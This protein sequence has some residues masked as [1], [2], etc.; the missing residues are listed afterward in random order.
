MRYPT[1][2]KTLIDKLKDGDSVSWDE[3]YEKY[4]KIIIDVGHAKGLTDDECNDLVQEVMLRFFQ[5]S[6]TFKFDPNI[7]KFRTYFSRIVAGKIIDI[8]RR[9]LHTFPEISKF[10]EFEFGTD[11]PPDVIFDDIIL[12]KWRK[13]LL[14]Q[15]KEILR[16][17][18]NAKT[19]SAFE[20]YAEQQRDV[21]RVSEALEM[22]E[23]QIYV[24]KNRCL[25]LLNTILRELHDADPEVE[26][27]THGV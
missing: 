16:S 5:K 19:Y 27:L 11:N 4:N 17:R 24:A 22:T 23:N 21:K 14:K 18:V 6:S 9:R 7:A 25:K 1:T 10:D 8:I 3:F 20:L 13:L 2:I 12:E 26:L 15:S